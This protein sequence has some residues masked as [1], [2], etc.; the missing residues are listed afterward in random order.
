MFGKVPQ[1][2]E[3]C[4][5]FQVSEIGELEPGFVTVQLLPDNRLKAPVIPKYTATDHNYVIGVGSQSQRRV[6]GFCRSTVRHAPVKR[7]SSFKLS[8]WSSLLA[9]KT[10][11]VFGP[12]SSRDSAMNLIGRVQQR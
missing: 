12:N 10:T 8:S 11:G 6:E 9:Q 4:R 5:H 2:F 7:E 3:E 1:L